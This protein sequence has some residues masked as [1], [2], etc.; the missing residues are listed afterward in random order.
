MSNIQLHVNIASEIYYRRKVKYSQRRDEL[1]FVLS[2]IKK[3]ILP[4]L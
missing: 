3:L 4:Y 2:L 1:V